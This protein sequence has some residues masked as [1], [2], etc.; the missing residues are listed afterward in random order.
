MVNLSTLFN[1]GGG[2]E[3]K[4]IPPK[5]KESIQ[6]PSL[7]LAKL[8]SVSLENIRLYAKV[9]KLLSQASSDELEVRLQSELDLLLHK[10]TQLHQEWESHPCN[11]SANSRL[12]WLFDQLQSLEVQERLLEKQLKTEEDAHQGLSKQY[13]LARLQDLEEVLKKMEVGNLCICI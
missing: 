4:R 1:S 10:Q 8:V 12:P 6:P 5:K 11:P 9:E 7:P 2:I 3:R 13:Y